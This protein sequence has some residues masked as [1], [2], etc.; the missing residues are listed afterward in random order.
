VGGR[1]ING[2]KGQMLEGGSRVPLVC[3]WPGVAPAGKV[4]KDLTDFS[5]MYATFA[6]L[7]GAPL[8][9]GVTIDGQSYAPQ[10]RGEPGKPREWIY[11]KLGNKWYVRSQ[12]WKLNQAGELF[13]MKAAP[14]VEKPV[15]AD[16]TDAAARAGREKLQKVLDTL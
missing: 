4:L 7:A 8:P 13:D 3:N 2:H 12:G 5:D 15:P 16:T 10:L 11:V 9:P 6:E 1:H 14:F